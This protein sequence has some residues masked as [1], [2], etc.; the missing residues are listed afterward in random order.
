MSPIVSFILLDKVLLGYYSTQER[1]NDQLVGSLSH[2]YLGKPPS[3][4]V[5]SYIQSEAFVCPKRLL[6]QTMRDPCLS[7][8]LNLTK[9]GEMFNGVGSSN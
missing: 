2:S 5:D 3:V 7:L 1:K 4:V 9:M 8:K 6:S